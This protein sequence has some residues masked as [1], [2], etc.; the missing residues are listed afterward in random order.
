MIPSI[1]S[2][3][4]AGLFYAII[5]KD[6][7]LDMQPANDIET[8]VVKSV[9]KDNDSIQAK[10]YINQAF[11]N[12]P[13]I[14]LIVGSKDDLSFT[15]DNSISGRIKIV[16]HPILVEDN[17]S[18]NIIDGYYIIFLQR[19]FL[20]IKVEDILPTICND[21]WCYCWEINNKFYNIAYSNE[22]V[23]LAS[24][25]QYIW[26]IQRYCRDIQNQDD[27]V[28][29]QYLFLKELYTALSDTSEDKIFLNDVKTYFSSY[30]DMIK[31]ANRMREFAEFK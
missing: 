6:G 26:F 27:I 9:I 10:S 19:K 20:N 14:N 11:K 31:K 2:P 16:P 15:D 30:A 12:S 3:A 8:E 28:G 21:M 7:W 25:Y 17:K 18:F 29:Q 5:G 23:E 24:I 13:I 1:Y 22:Y 4:I